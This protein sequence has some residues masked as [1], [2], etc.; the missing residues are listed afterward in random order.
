MVELFNRRIVSSTDSIN[1]VKDLLLFKNISSIKDFFETS[2]E[3]ICN[4]NE[5]YFF[6][7]SKVNDSKV[8]L[9]QRGDSIEQRVYA[10]ALLNWIMEQHR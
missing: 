8:Y 1:N 5:N 3:V 4:F 10:S 9:G 6:H 2:L 7:E